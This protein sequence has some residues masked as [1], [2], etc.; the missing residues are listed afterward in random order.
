M[1]DLGDGRYQATMANGAAPIFTGDAGRQAYERL[2]K[3]QNAGATAENRFGAPG[4]VRMGTTEVGEPRGGWVEREAQDAPARPVPGGYAQELA[5]NP[6]PAT[7]QAQPAAPSPQQSGP[8]LLPYAV[9]GV[10]P[11]TGKEVTGRGVMMP[12]G[13]MMVMRQGTAGSPGGVTALGK[14]VLHNRQATEEAAAPYEA[15]AAAAREAGKDIAIEQV[16]KQKAYLEEQRT[17][18]MLRAQNERD[19]AMAAEQHVASLQ[20]K[21]DAAAEEFANSRMPEQSGADKFFTGLGASLGAFGASLGKTPN[22]AQEFINQLATNRMRKWEAETNVKGAKANNLLARYKDALGDMKLA[23][24]AVKETLMRQAAIEADQMALSTKSEQIGNT[25]REMSNAAASQGIRAANEKQEAFLLSFYGN[26]MLNRPATAGTPGGLIPAT[27]E[28]YGKL[29][30]QQLDEEAMRLKKDAALRDANGTGT[31]ADKESVAR[32]EAFTAAANVVGLADRILTNPALEGDDEWYEPSG[33]MTPGFAR[34]KEQ[35][36]LRQD[37][38]NYINF[39]IKAMTGAGLSEQEAKRLAAAEVGNGSKN[40]IRRGVQN[41]MDAAKLAARQ[42]LSVSTGA[43]Q[44]DFLSPLDPRTRS[45][46]GG[47]PK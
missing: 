24:V 10:D 14:Q 44:Q 27:Q 15:E 12:D 23:K 19:E 6:K 30:G 22:F 2:K 29:Q 1:Q 38:Q 33:S 35:N 20:A 34:S 21:A 43:R 11:A 40:A 41:G 4:A 13:S 42:H 3:Q 25:W 47:G 36:Q 31:G 5:E 7:S 9:K 39:R 16:E 17:Q 46:I 26:K 45:I 18:A 28:S 37:L 8:S 32:V